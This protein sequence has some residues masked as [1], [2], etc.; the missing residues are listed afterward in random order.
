MKD[1]ESLPE[2]LDPVNDFFWN[3]DQYETEALQEASAHLQKTLDAKYVPA[4]LNKVIWTCRHLTKDKNVNCMP[5]CA[6]KNIFL[7]APWGHGEMNL[8]ILNL[9]N[10]LY[11][12]IYHELLFQKFMSTL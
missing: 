12:S 9:K 11:L 4:D 7:M 6:N 5:Y 8:I 3:N 1:P 10:G 2:L